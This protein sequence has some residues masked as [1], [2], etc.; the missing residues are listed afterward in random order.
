MCV[1]NILPKSFV[2]Y[3]SVPVYGITQLGLKSHPTGSFT[4]ETITTTFSFFRSDKLVYTTVSSDPLVL[5]N[6]G[7]GRTYLFSHLESLSVPSRG[8][9]DF[10]GHLH[11]GLVRPHGDSQISGIWTRSDRRLHHRLNTLELKAVIL[12]LH[13]WVSVLRGH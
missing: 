1:P 9:Y 3:R 10:H 8:G 13:H 2:V 6:L 4:P 5:A 7:N 11:P 12:A